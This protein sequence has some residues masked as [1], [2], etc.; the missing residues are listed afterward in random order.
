MR[1]R[2]DHNE[3]QYRAELFERLIFRLLPHVYPNSTVIYDFIVPKTR[4][5]ASLSVDFVVRSAD[6]KT[7]VVETKAPYTDTASYGIN[8]TIRRLK[9][10]YERF[11]DS[12][13][14]SEVV[15]ALASDLPAASASEVEDTK[16]FFEQKGVHFRVWDATRVSHLLAKH[17]N[18]QLHSFTVQNLEKVVIAVRSDD[19]LEIRRR[20][21]TSSRPRTE[22]EGEQEDVIVLVADFCSYTKFVAASG[23]DKALISSVMGRFYR[24][25]REIVEQHG[26]IIDKYMGDGLLA[27]WRSG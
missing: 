26:G 20:A 7:I 11:S 5:N 13:R 8:R 10:A 27:C 22:I 4:G 25:M 18:I 24:Q 3:G 23:G 9:Y 16:R 1:I 21:A 12:E 17:L 6:G 19:V 14:P 2:I 15:V